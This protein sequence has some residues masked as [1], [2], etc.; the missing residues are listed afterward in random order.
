MIMLADDID[1]VESSAPGSRWLVWRA[2]EGRL[3]VMR[4][5]RGKEAIV[6]GSVRQSR[7]TPRNLS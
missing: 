5:G 3:H 7:L 4:A 2:G 6:T 1:C